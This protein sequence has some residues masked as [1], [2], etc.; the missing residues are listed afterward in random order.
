MLLVLCDLAEEGKLAGALLRRDGDLVF[1]FSSYWKVVA[2]RRQTKPDISFPFYHLKSEGFWQALAADGRPATDRRAAV[3]AQMEAPFLVCLSHPKFRSLARRTLIAKY[4]QPHERAELYSLVELPVPPED[5]I[6]ADAVRFLPEKESG[7][8]RDAKF[9]VRVLPAYDYTCALTSYRMLALNGK[10]ALDAAHIH[11]LKLGGHNHP[12][13]GIALAKTAHWLF[14]HGFWSIGD[15]FT[16]LVAADRFDEAG[17]ASHLLKPRAGHPILLPTSKHYWP[18]R[19]CLKWHRQQ[20]GFE[21][22]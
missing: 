15:D 6:A 19:E 5:V 17:D 7:S 14:D 16:I 1:R 18:A 10:T 8:Q 22:R 2:P 21:T 12:T 3:L 13:N 9:A 20:H 11:Q 4:F